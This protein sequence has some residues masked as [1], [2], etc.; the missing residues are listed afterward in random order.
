MACGPFDPEGDP[1]L[2]GLCL[3]RIPLDQALTVAEADPRVQAG[4]LVVEGLT[5]WTGEGH[6]AFPLAPADEL[7]GTAHDAKGGAI[8]A[9]EDGRVVYLQGVDG[10]PPGLS[11]T[12]V[13]ARGR[14]V[15]KSYLPEASVAPDG[16]ISQGVAAGSVQWV[17]EL[18]SWQEA[19]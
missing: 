2:R 5:W 6:L 9:L 8:L 11:G 18:P 14:L 3:F 17:L 12:Q 16:A 4:Q 19:P 7:I 1:E 10:W 13:Q 15:Q